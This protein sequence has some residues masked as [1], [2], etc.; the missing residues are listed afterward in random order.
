M[1][2]IIQIETLFKQVDKYGKTTVELYKYR[3]ISKI[4]DMLSKL[5]LFAIVSIL[6]AFSFLFVCIAAAYLIGN[7]FGKIYYGFILVAALCAFIALIIYFV[8]GKFI[9]GTLRNSF[10]QFLQF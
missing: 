7:Y 4:S 2:N 6:A 1:D 8:R 9:V 5:V 3:A 10:I